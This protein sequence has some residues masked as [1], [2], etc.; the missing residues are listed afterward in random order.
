MTNTQSNK[1]LSNRT[2]VRQRPTDDELRLANMHSIL[3]D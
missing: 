1:P 2:E 3:D